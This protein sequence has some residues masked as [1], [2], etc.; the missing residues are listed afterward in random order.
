MVVN[1]GAFFDVRNGSS[2]IDDGTI[3]SS[4]LQNFAVSR[5]DGYIEF[6]ALGRRLPAYNGYYQ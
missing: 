2:G 1:S 6:L 5:H 3:I 4:G